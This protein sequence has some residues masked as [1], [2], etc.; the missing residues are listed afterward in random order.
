MFA[1]AEG[2]TIIP[3]IDGRFIDILSESSRLK[4]MLLADDQQLSEQLQ[5]HPPSNVMQFSK[6][7][8]GIALRD[9]GACLQR[10]AVIFQAILHIFY[11]TLDFVDDFSDLCYG[12]DALQ[13]LPRCT[14]A[15]VREYAPRLDL[16][17][18]LDLLNT[19][20]VAAIE[21][22]AYVILEFLNATW[23][24]G[25]FQLFWHKDMDARL[26]SFQKRVQDCA[27]KIPANLARI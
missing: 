9:K 17:V 23:S 21:N 27:Y 3:L 24:K 10:S 22:V 11:L 5:N 7:K 18:T 6:N 13:A 16:D 25:L 2:G 20:P 14:N 1:A 12:F 26:L 15:N 4:K 8:Y 19:M